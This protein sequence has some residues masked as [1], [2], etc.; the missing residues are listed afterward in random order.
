MHTQEIRTQN[1]S[2]GKGSETI[3]WCLIWKVHQRGASALRTWPH[4]TFNRARFVSRRQWNFSVSSHVS[5]TRD[6]S[7][8]GSDNPNTSINTIYATIRQTNNQPIRQ[9][10]SQTSDL[11]MAVSDCKPNQ[12][13]ND[14]KTM[15]IRKKQKSA[16]VRHH[17]DNISVVLVLVCVMHACFMSCRS[18]A[19]VVWIS[20]AFLNM[21]YFSKLLPCFF[22]SNVSTG[23]T[24]KCI[25]FFTF[26]RN[27]LAR[28]A[29]SVR[30]NAKDRGSSRLA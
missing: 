18:A 22:S 13:W 5:H 7:F 4:M 26:W 9:T 24:K 3:R 2:L 12:L 14:W 8:C 21:K 29:M 23:K 19:V 1:M 11:S 16:S 30:Q 25:W 6:C 17:Q 20:F 10:V 15:M 28:F 27:A